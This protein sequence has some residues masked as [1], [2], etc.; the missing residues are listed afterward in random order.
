MPTA[1][2]YMNGV[3]EPAKHDSHAAMRLEVMAAAGIRPGDDNS[4]VN[5]VPVIIKFPDGRTVQT[6]Y[7]NAIQRITNNGAVLVTE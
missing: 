6:S 4:C 5:P 7:D 1:R 3:P 2:D